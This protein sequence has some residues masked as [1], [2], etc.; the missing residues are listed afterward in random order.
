MSAGL[1]A[2]GNEALG[3]EAGAEATSL[4]SLNPLPDPPGAR[5]TP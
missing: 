5:E 4:E 3:R 1:V 2:P